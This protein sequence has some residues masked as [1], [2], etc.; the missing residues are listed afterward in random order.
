[1]SRTVEEC[2][3]ALYQ[4]NK[5]RF[6]FV[7]L[8]AGEQQILTSDPWAFLSSYLQARSLKAR[9]TNREKIERALYFASL[10]G[11]FFRAAE[12]V[13]LCVLCGEHTS[14]ATGVNA[15]VK[16]AQDLGKPYFLLSGR[17]GK[18]QK[19]SAAN[20]SDKLYAWT[21]DNLKALVGGG[22]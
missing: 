15:E 2:E 1:M 5:L 3:L 13:E 11:D 18:S 4:Y 6:S 17:G 21:W 14:G 8:K 7:D 9:G 22:R 10:A 16:I 12:S 20:A 19:P